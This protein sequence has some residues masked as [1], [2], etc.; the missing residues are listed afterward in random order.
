MVEKRNDGYRVTAP[1]SLAYDIMITLFIFG[2]LILLTGLT[3]EPIMWILV[4]AG[5]E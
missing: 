1:S 5:M 3:V 2:T 4:V